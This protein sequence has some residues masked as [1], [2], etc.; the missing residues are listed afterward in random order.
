M[1]MVYISKTVERPNIAVSTPLRWLSNSVLCKATVTHSYNQ[2]AMDL[3]R[4]RERSYIGNCVKRFTRALI[5]II[6]C[7]NQRRSKS[8]I[9][10]RPYR[11]YS[12]GVQCSFLQPKIAWRLGYRQ[13]SQLRS[14]W[15]NKSLLFVLFL[16]LSTICMPLCLTVLYHQAVFMYSQHNTTFL[17]SV[18]TIA[19]GHF[20]GAKYTHHTFTPIIKQH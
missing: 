4:S 6:N 9:H 16:M 12:Q 1:V 10:F 11:T 17:P 15:N 7:R 8:L 18:S 20:C 2:S 13:W 5:I 3:P 19:L 14:E